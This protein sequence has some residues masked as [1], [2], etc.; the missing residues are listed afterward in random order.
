MSF[1]V[2]AA[3]NGVIIDPAKFDTSDRIRRCGTDTHPKSKNGAYKFDGDRGWVYRW[4]G[5]MKPIWFGEKPRNLS[6]QEQSAIA[7]RRAYTLN[8]ERLKHAQSINRAVL[9]LGQC[10]QAE[11]NYFQYKGFKEVK[12]LVTPDGDLFVPMRDWKTN[13]LK[14]AQIIRWDQNAMKYSKKMLFGM[15][16]SES[17]YIMGPKSPRK[18]ILVEGYATALSV[19]MACAQLC[20]SVRVVVCFSSGNLVKV[21]KYFDSAM[22]YADN[23]KSGAGLRAAQ[24]SGLSFCMSPTE[25]HDAN[26]DHRIHGLRFVSSKIMDGFAAQQ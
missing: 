22:V 7:E 2:F 1:I 12:G 26:D 24:E 19:Q 3:C 4:D 9:M 16:A 10:R 17:V 8:Q 18:T 23:D 15:E 20:L 21:A 5:D 11:H 25:G 6:H 14:G 13:A